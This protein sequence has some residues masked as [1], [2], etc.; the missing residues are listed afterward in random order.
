[1]PVSSITQLLNACFLNNSAAECQFPQYLCSWIPFYCNVCIIISLQ[2]KLSIQFLLQY[3]IAWTLY[4]PID[5]TLNERILWVHPEGAT[6]TDRIAHPQPYIGDNID[7]SEWSKH[8]VQYRYIWLPAYVIN[9]YWM[10][11][12]NYT[13]STN[14]HFK[15]K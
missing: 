9:T 14:L 8:V 4:E 15:Y 11:T 6:S 10:T 5:A 3:V 1:M 13:L 7:P 2:W 12:D